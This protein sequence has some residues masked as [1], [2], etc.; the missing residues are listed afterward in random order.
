MF[1]F[2]ESCHRSSFR[3]QAA[4]VT[5]GDLHVVQGY[6]HGFYNGGVLK[7]VLIF[8]SESNI[9]HAEQRIHAVSAGE[10]CDALEER[11]AFSHTQRV[12]TAFTDAG[13]Q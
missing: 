4:Q 1:F 3:I 13:M 6:E 12:L 10:S 5:D 8:A 11:I 2:L 9:V 7:E